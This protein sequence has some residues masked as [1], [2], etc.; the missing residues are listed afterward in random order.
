MGMLLFVLL[1]ALMATVGFWDTLEAVVGAAVLMALAVLTGIVFL[2][3]GG[4]VLLRRGK[5]E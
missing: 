1:V 5:G 3:L 4:I 2:V